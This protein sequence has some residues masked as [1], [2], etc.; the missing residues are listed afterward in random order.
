MKL[1][2]LLTLVVAAA[3][4]TGI[5]D[6]DSYKAGDAGDSGTKEDTGG[7]CSA[8]SCLAC[9]LAKC[10]G[11]A[12]CFGSGAILGDF[13]GGLCPKYGACLC[14]CT[15]ATCSAACAAQKSA[16]VACGGCLDTATTPSACPAVAD[17]ASKC[18]S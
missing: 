9:L 2:P 12:T 3:G 13:S 4:C 10:S 1:G 16:D 18:G 14:K 15:D 8:D 17:C 11:A 7:T 6:L 5:L